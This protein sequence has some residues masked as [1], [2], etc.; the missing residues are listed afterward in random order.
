VDPTGS[1]H[2]V[3]TKELRARWIAMAEAVGR[4]EH[5]FEPLKAGA[6]AGFDSAS[7]F[8]A[9]KAADGDALA[10]R[11]FEQRVR[12]VRRNRLRQQSAA[13]VSDFESEFFTINSAEYERFRSL[14]YRWELPQ[15]ASSLA[16]FQMERNPFASF[17]E[18]LLPML[19]G[20][21]FQER[22]S[23]S[24]WSAEKRIGETTVSLEVE[25]REKVLLMVPAVSIPAFDFRPPLGDLFFFSHVKIPVHRGAALGEIAGRLADDIRIVLPSMLQM[26]NDA[27]NSLRR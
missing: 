2:A 23:R 27:I 17:R 6:G 16:A 13:E 1:L 24:R 19:T 20:A 26:L 8:L 11:A 3:V 18:A 4:F 7:R 21:G 14:H 12:L 25:R 5:P 10:R 22:A 15:G 9:L